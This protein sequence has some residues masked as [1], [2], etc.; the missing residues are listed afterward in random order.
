MDKKKII[1]RQEIKVEPIKSDEELRERVEALEL[2]RKRSS[3]FFR[4]IG[5]EVNMLMAENKVIR[6][7]IENQSGKTLEE[8]HE[9][10]ESDPREEV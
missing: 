8:L 2:K 1:K 5:K 6:W 7:Y 9:E 4:D 3:Q 10:I